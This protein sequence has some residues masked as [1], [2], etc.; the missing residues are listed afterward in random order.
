MGEHKRNGGVSR[1]ARREFGVSM[2]G[3][4]A[5]GERVGWMIN[6]VIDAHPGTRVEDVVLCV[7]E[8]GSQ[9]HEAAVRAKVAS[10]STPYVHA[11]RRA[12]SGCPDVVNTA[13]PEG[14]LWLQVGLKAPGGMVYGVAA[15]RPVMVDGLVCGVVVAAADFDRGVNA[16]GAL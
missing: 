13:P 8:P 12:R 5:H 4:S 6:E 9:N 7:D 14:C 16:G 3:M 2:A 1:A 10:T 11:R 15:A